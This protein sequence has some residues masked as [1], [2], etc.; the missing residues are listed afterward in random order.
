[1][2]RVLDLFSGIGGF[3]LGLSRT[4]RFKTVAFCEVDAYCN[5]VLKQWWPR[6]PNFDCGVV[7]LNAL[8]K[9]ARTSSPRAS[10]ARTYPLLAEAPDLPAPIP[11]SCGRFY[12][13]FA[14]FDPATRSWRTWQRC[15]IEGWAPYAGTWPRSGMTRSGIAFRRAALV[16]RTEEIGSGSSLPTESAT[17]YGTNQGGGMGRVGP[18]RPSL[19]SMARHDLWP[20]PWASA[21]GPDF[22]KQD[23]SSTGLSLE[24]AVALWPTPKASDH[25]PGMANRAVGRRRNLNDAT[26]MWPTPTA[27]D[28]RSSGSRNTP[29]SKAHPGVSLTDAV[30]GDMG[31]GRVD[32]T[33]AHRDWRSGKGRQANGHTP[34]LPEVVG[35]QLSPQFVEW[36]MGFPIGWTD[37][38][39]SATASS[40]SSRKSLGKPSRQPKTDEAD[41][42]AA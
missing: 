15:L 23:R 1:M 40:R 3:S 26:Q 10:R 13:P 16:P 32:P 22:A 19:E 39:G 41:E 28:A 33:P 38:K 2:L 4:G 6:I 36:L 12:E 42:A 27:G 34:Q 17:T 37:L 25:R 20:T 5:K 18:V 31:R 29:G 11:G 21:S 14:W 35:G 8:L 7:G 30:R 9:R 24:T